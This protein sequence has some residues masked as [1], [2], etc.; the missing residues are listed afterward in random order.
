MF[1]CSRV[2][3]GT[4]KSINA[5]SLEDPHSSSHTNNYYKTIATFIEGCGTNNF[6]D[7]KI[8]MDDIPN[9][10]AAKFLILLILPPASPSSLYLLLQTMLQSSETYFS[11]FCPGTSLIKSLLRTLSFSSLLTSIFPSQFF[12]FMFPILEKGFPW[13]KVL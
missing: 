4:A 2:I 8:H 1:F 9:I 6:D 12:L 13:E 7:F 10:L 11:L 3:V 5:E